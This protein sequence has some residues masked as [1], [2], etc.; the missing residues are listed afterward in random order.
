MKHLLGVII[1][2]RSPVLDRES[3]GPR[4]GMTDLLQTERF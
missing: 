2:V 1:F 3:Y 4:I